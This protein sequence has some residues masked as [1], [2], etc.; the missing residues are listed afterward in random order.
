[1]E[2]FGLVEGR[3]WRVGSAQREIS[4][5]K[6]APKGF[7]QYYKFTLWSTLEVDSWHREIQK[8]N[9]TVSKKFKILGEDVYPKLIIRMIILSF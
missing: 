8:N 9:N 2:T 1:M 5:K 7:T 4:N 6:R 3:R